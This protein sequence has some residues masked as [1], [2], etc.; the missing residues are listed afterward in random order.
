MAVIEGVSWD[1]EDKQRSAGKTSTTEDQDAIQ[2]VA[3]LPWAGRGLVTRR[4]D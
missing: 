3:I 4:Y 1:S 2:V